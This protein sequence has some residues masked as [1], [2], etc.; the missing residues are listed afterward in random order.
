[1]GKEPELTGHRNERRE[2]EIQNITVTYVDIIIMYC[3][4]MLIK[5]P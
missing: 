2:K 4:Y 1:M 5:K 3:K